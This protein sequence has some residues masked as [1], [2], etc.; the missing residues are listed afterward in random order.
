MRLNLIRVVLGWCLVTGATTQAQQRPLV[1]EDPE[2]I[3]TGRLLVESGFDYRWDQRFAASGLE[4]DLWRAP[5]LGLSFGLG[6]TAELQIDGGFSRLSI[7]DRT[8]APLTGLLE[9][10]G[11]H[12]SSAEDVVVATKVRLIAETESRPAFG[13]RFATRLPNASNESGLGLD[14]TDFL[15]SMLAAKTAASV[16]VVGN[17]GLGI[18]GD[19]TSATDQNDVLLY[20]VSF[21][22]ALTNQAEVVAEV[23]GHV[24]TRSGE[25]P[26]GTGSR[27]LVRLGTRYTL[28]PGRFDAALLFGLTSDEPQLGFAVGY[29]HV[30][31]AFTTP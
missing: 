31:N 4:G 20:G 22:R 15:V 21:A 7:T 19:P 30:F 28:G 12:S 18:L 29:T 25:P 10:D 2:T 26:A 23:N 24:S 16:R 13:V 6:A 3:G 9:V 1:T 8:A 5:L 17:V 27:S 14:T 11:D